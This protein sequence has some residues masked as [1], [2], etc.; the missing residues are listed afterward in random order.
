MSRITALVLLLA[1]SRD[2]VVRRF[3]VYQVND[4]SRLAGLNFQGF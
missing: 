3:L 1:V 2:S 4:A